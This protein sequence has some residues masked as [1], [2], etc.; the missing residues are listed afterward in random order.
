M[1]FLVF[2]V[3][4]P[5]DGLY[6]K[7][8]SIYTERRLVFSVWKNFIGYRNALS[9]VHKM[10]FHF[11]LQHLKYWIP[12]CN[13]LV[14]YGTETFLL[15]YISGWQWFAPSPNNKEDG[16]FE[17][18]DRPLPFCFVFF[19][20]LLSWFYTGAPAPTEQKPVAR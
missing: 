17:P 10:I 15:Q 9:V 20:H 16:R 2:Y 3:Q 19:S 12:F 1:A 7:F 18:V 11:L 5:Q 8:T 4:P 13:S 14:I 6:S